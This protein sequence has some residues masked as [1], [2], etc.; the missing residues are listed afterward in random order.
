MK[1]KFPE[2]K[3]LIRQCFIDQDML[4]SWTGTSLSIIV[5]EIFVYF[6]FVFTLVFFVGRSR[7]LKRCG[8]DNSEQFEDTYCSYLCDRIIQN[9]VYK[10]DKFNEKFKFSNY[11]DRERTVEIDNVLIKVRLPS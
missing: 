6:G 4:N 2:H 3:H 7:F 9:I 11:V 5:I 8:V 10:E 1:N